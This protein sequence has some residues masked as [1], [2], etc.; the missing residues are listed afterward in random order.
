M[1]VLVEV[2]EVVM[3]AIVASMATDNPIDRA[4]TSRVYA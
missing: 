3:V 2:E 4:D 1:A